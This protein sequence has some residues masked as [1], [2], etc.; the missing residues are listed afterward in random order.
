M[1]RVITYTTS[2]YYPEMDIDD[3]RRVLEDAKK[4]EIPGYVVP[5]VILHN[6]GTRS[7]AQAIKQ[8]VVEG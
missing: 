1:K 6:D 2:R 5:R 3:L 4:L 7:R 8:V